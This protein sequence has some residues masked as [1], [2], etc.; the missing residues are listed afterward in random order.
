MTL[1]DYTERVKNIHQMIAKHYGNFSPR[2]L[3]REIEKVKYFIDH[4]GE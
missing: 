2:N 3:R 4:P 1:E